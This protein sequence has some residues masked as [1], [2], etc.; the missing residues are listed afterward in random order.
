MDNYSLSL[1][2]SYLIL[3]IREH[4]LSTGAVPRSVLRAGDKEEQVESDEV[5]DVSTP[6]WEGGPRGA[7]EVPVRASEASG[8]GGLQAGVLRSCGI[9]LCPSVCRRKEGLMG[10]PRQNP[11]EPLPGEVLAPLP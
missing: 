10:Q 6:K 2:I 9:W 8:G 1:A 11:G 4:L 5:A 3:F 7:G